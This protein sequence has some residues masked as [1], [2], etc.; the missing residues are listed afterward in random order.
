MV[1]VLDGC[2]TQVKYKDDTSQYKE[3]LELLQKDIPAGKSILEFTTNTE[4]SA[5]LVEQEGE[6]LCKPEKKRTIAR[7]QRQREISDAESSAVDVMNVLSLGLVKA[8]GDPRNNKTP[9]SHISYIDSEKEII[10]NSSSYVMNQVAGGWV[11]SSCGPLFIKFTP[12]EGRRYKINFL[13][14][15]SGC[16]SLLTNVENSKQSVPGHAQWSCTKPVMGLG[17]N[18]IIGFKEITA[19]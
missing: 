3:G 5:T 13:T 19:N 7:V 6:N 1:L 15:G 2:S 18:E 9:V 17:G 10:L 16:A 14:L 12:K 4:I 11:S 8:L